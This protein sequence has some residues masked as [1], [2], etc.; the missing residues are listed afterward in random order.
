V[1]FPKAFYAVPSVG[2]TAQ[3]MDSG[4]Y[5]VVSNVTRTGF[6]VSFKDSGAT[7]VSRTFDYQAVGHGREIV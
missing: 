1:T 4:D 3:D 6:D 7:L 2:I 5:F